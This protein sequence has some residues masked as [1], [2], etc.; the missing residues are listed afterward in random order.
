[1][2]EIKKEKKQTILNFNPDRTISLPK[3]IQKELDKRA[4]ELDIW[5]DNFDEGY[6]HLDEPIGNFNLY[7]EGKRKEALKFSNNTTQE[8]VVNEVVSLIKAGKKVIFIK[9]V[10]GTGKSAIA[11]NIAKEI[12]SASIVVPGKALQ[13]QYEEDYSNKKYVLKKDH[14]K[15]KIKV[16]TGRENHL[17]L[18]KKGVSANNNEL[19]CKIEIKEKNIDKLRKYLKENP[20]VK[21]DLEL[22]NIKRMSIAPVC[23]YWSPVVTSNIELNLNDVLEKRTYRGLNGVPFTIYKRKKG[24]TYYGQFNS[25]IDAEVI[26]FNSAKYK[27]EFLMNRKPLTKVDIIDECDE[28]LDSFSNTRSINLQRFSNSLIK[29]H[30]DNENINKISDKIQDILS[31]LNK[32]KKNEILMLKETK[33]YELFNLL[34]KNKF[35][36]DEVDEESYIHHVFEIA[37][38]FEDLLDEAF[39]TFRIDNNVV[40]LDIVSVNLAKRFNELKEKNNA[41]VLMSGTIHS[42]SALKNI[43]GIN[44]YE[45]INAETINQGA[46]EIA[47]LGIE[48]DCSYINFQQKRITREE[49]LKI[50]NEIIRKSKKP[51]LVHVN[52]F[53]D[54]PDEHEKNNLNLENLITKARLKD[55]QN[56]N[57]SEDLIQ[58]FKN[59]EIPVLFTTKCSRGIDFPGDECNSIIFTKYPNPSANDIFWKILKKVHENYYWAFYKDKAYRE[60]LQKIYRGV[61]SKDDK[62]YVMSPD[63]RVLDSTAKLFSK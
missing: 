50:L 35:F 18:Y 21:D 37:L 55:I 57:D 51:A 38:E 41:L 56:N 30:S 33:A 62:V 12:G 47:Y 32:E 2:E 15:L 16:I 20:K 63:K 13:K 4:K 53:E 39:V 1:M 19:P 61:R 17:C 3:E 11:L 10:C 59:K 23:P 9:G 28:F 31:K 44:D 54:L 58:K 34:L 22:K 7:D 40:F 49:Y 48:K 25:Y 27:L 29:S 43:F 26:V 36:I 46:I 60:F 8:D 42:E 45:I 24:C 14:K 52:S 6:Y 5:E